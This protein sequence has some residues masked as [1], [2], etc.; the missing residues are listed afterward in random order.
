MATS[1]DDDTF[2]VGEVT[3]HD[4]D[5]SPQ[6]SLSSPPFL[7]DPSSRTTTPHL[8]YDQ[9]ESVHYSEASSSLL[10]PM[11]AMGPDDEDYAN[12]NVTPQPRES[13]DSTPPDETLSPSTGEPPLTLTPSTGTQPSSHP[14]TS[15]LPPSDEASVA[16]S[17]VSNS[18]F[19]SNKSFASDKSN[20]SQASSNSNYE[21]SSRQSGAKLNLAFLPV[22]QH[23]GASSGGSSYYSRTSKHSVRRKDVIKPVALPPAPTPSPPKNQAIKDAVVPSSQPPK[24]QWSLPSNPQAGCAD[25]IAASPNDNTYTN[26]TLPHTADQYALVLRTHDD[27]HASPR[28][29]DPSE[30]IRGNGRDP[31]G[32]EPAAR[33]SPSSSPYA[34]KYRNVQWVDPKTITDESE[35]DYDIL[36]RYR[37]LSSEH[38]PYTRYGGAGGRGGDEPPPQQQQ[39]R[40]RIATIS[41]G[42]KT[43]NFFVRED[44]DQRIY[45]HELEDAVSYMARRGY[46]RME[47]GEEMEWMKLLGRA[48]QVVKV[49]P[50]KKKQRYRKGKLVLIMY[51]PIVNG[52]D[53]YS[54]VK[55]RHH[56][57]SD[58]STTSTATTHTSLGR[59][60]RCGYKSYSEKFLAEQEYEKRQGLLMLTNGEPMDAPGNNESNATAPLLQLTNGV[61]T[62]SLVEEE[63]SRSTS[64]DKSSTNSNARRGVYGGGIRYFTPD[65]SYDEDEE[66]DDDESSEEEEKDDYDEEEA[67][68][69][70]VSEEFIEVEG[71]DMGSMFSEDEGSYHPVNDGVESV[72]SSTINSEMSSIVRNSGGVHMAS[73]QKYGNRNTLN[74]KRA[75]TPFDKSPEMVP[76]SDESESGS[77]ERQ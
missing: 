17:L 75:P 32:E 66:S 11:P 36:N 39:P 60:I 7:L 51:K 46:A 62:M 64:S 2:H 9:D 49:G 27:T 20:F 29:I 34:K 38:G 30:T 69:N 56:I 44:L 76:I 71:S 28:G 8:R 68:G 24:S 14:S 59:S 37:A 73:G 65:R 67:G 61:S 4:E 48:H 16:S 33:P 15:D 6:D 31:P 25:L 70:L 1:I 43:A 10:T 18:T 41:S 58:V 47:R 21:T 19:S 12:W 72:A 54:D 45:F 63:K 40:I 50:T 3:Q 5:S 13:P 22:R 57:S 35:I 77:W 53:H 26:Y 52:V 55:K 74:K 42:Y 23:S